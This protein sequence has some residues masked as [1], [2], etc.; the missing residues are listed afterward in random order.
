VGVSAL[1]YSHKLGNG[2]LPQSYSFSTPLSDIL[3]DTQEDLH[4]IAK[5]GGSI[6]LPFRLSSRTGDQD[7]SELIVVSTGA[8]G[9]SSSVKVVAA[10]HN[11]VNN[12]YSVQTTE[13][14]SK[15]LIW[16]PA[17]TPGSSSTT[18]PS[19][20]QTPT[21]IAGSSVMP[22]EGRIDSFPQVAEVTFNDRIVIFPIDSGLPPIYVMFSNPY[23]GADTKG[24]YS[25]RMYNPN[26]AGGP[27][28][29]LNWE[30]ATIT[31]A[32]IDLVKLH[33]GRFE[34]SAANDVMIDRLSKI[35]SKEIES[36]D[37]D[38]RF[39]TH[40]IRELERYRALGIADN[41]QGDVWNNAHTA[42]LEDFKLK[43]DPNLLY[44]SEATDAYY[45]QQYGKQP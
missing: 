34:A 17:E 33:T 8:S 41:V 31:Q 24:K 32:G 14:P 27:T 10:T 20:E 13:T 4:A 9:V 29:D 35:L 5:A 39:Y 40:E 45:E 7:V 44:T 43:D 16:T 37:I 11:P 36:T 21:V 38:K 12:T 18:L 23:K 42:T 1:I 19:E 26:N 30:T 28:Q 22:V 25:G 2:E 3:P 6:E 15:T